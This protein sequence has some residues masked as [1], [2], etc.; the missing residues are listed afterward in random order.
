MWEQ[1][2]EQLIVLESGADPSIDWETFLSEVHAAFETWW[3][4]RRRRIPFRL[5]VRQHE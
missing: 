1:E 2:Q 4:T 5:C 3:T